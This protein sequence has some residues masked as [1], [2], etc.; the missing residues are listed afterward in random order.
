MQL[1]P[2]KVTL[3]NGYTCT[4]LAPD[5]DAALSQASAQFRSLWKLS[6]SRI[7]GKEVVC[8]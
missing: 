2:F 3:S 6:T 4:V 5:K 7:F 1:K 8:L